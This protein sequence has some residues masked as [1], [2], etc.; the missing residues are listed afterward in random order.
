MFYLPG[1]PF[2]ILPSPAPS[3]A[4]NPKNLKKKL[5]NLYVEELPKLMDAKSVNLYNQPKRRCQE[6]KPVQAGSHL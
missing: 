2:R 1:K 5:W 3:S 4:Q 6:K